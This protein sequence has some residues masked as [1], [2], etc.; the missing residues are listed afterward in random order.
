MYDPRKYNIKLYGRK[1]LPM[2][3]KYTWVAWVIRWN[4]RPAAD[5]QVSLFGR[6]TFLPSWCKHWNHMV[7]LCTHIL[8]ASFKDNLCVCVGSVVSNSS[9]PM[10]CGQPGSSVHGII[11]TRILEWVA[12]S[13]SRGS[14][15]PRNWTCIL[16]GSCTG[17]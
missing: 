16:C 11:L 4:V 1:E 15:Q 7:S 9:D 5:M 17:K 6:I 12:I 10:D 13:S 14:S 8:S 2:H 3:A